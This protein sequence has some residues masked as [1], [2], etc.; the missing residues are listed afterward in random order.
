M[1][2]LEEELNY[3]IA[4]HECVPLTTSYHLYFLRISK[5][6][7]MLHHLSVG[8]SLELNITLCLL[9]WLFCCFSS[10]NVFVSFSLLFLMKH[11]LHQSQTRNGNNKVSVERY[12]I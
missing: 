12:E 7:S 2:T 10:K 4:Q 5:V 6:W 3:Q 8:A 1:T 11:Q 9:F